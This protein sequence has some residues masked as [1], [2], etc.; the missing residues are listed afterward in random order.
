[1]CNT[2]SCY[3][4]YI[5]FLTLFL[6]PSFT[7]LPEAVSLST[8]LPCNEVAKETKNKSLCFFQQGYFSC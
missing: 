8:A 3:F 1:M 2:H 5:P 7:F 6:S 4:V